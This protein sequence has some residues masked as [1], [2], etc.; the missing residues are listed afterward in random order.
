MS[1]P[2]SENLRTGIAVVVLVAIAT[3]ALTVARAGPVPGGD[4]LPPSG[5]GG[6]AFAGSHAAAGGGRSRPGLGVRGARTRPR[7]DPHRRARHAARSIR[8]RAGRWRQR[9][10]RR[11]LSASR[12]R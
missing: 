9:R 6:L 11:P 8:G 3:T 1:A 2:V 5:G 10:L 4:V 7:P 12:A